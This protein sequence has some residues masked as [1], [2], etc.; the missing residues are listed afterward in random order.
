MPLSGNEMSAVFSRQSSA[1]FA[2]GRTDERQSR[3]KVG[4]PTGVSIDIRFAS[5]QLPYE[6]EG[7]KRKFT[8]RVLD[9]GAEICLAYLLFFVLKLE[10]ICQKKF[11]IRHALRVFGSVTFGGDFFAQIPQIRKGRAVW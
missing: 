6:V 5:I 11:L 2:T 10:C 8:P 9:S 3:W 4:S 7:R 1:R